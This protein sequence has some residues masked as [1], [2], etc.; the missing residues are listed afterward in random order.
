MAGTSLDGVD[1]ALVAFAP[2]GTP[3]LERF[4]TTPYPDRLRNDLLALIALGDVPAPLVLDDALGRLF[5]E[6][7]IAVR[8]DASVDFVG[9]H[10]QTVW[11]D[12]GVASRQIGNPAIIAAACH[13]PVVSDFRRADIAA[14]GQGAP[15]VPL[16]DAV[17]F[18][19]PDG[20]RTLLNIGGMANATYVPRLGVEDG[21]IAFDTGPGV[22][23]MD[24]VA[25][26]VDPAL[27]C[28]LDGRLA[29]AGRA[30]EALLAELLADPWFEVP[31][32]KS[33][34]RER[35]GQAVAERIVAAC[36]RTSDA[37]ATATAFTARSIVA[38]LDRW[39]PSSRGDLLVAGGGLH[40]RTL[41]TSLPPFL[42]F[43]DCFFNADAKEALV[44]AWLGW[45]TLHGLPGN[46]PAATGARG[47]RVLGS[48]VGTGI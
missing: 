33:T 29:A 30:D 47:P 6:A 15:L 34:G 35:F 32:P 2:D 23:I 5:A 48:V 7:A 19:N 41:C 17:L 1:A 11:H 12:P 4:V 39:L 9:S 22:A 36:G 24:L 26:A 37:V 3:T 20:P 16:A 13:V 25:R 28:D 14:G 38:Q 10:G 8:A 18:G 45:R 46:L 31:P 43:S 42:P 44:F 27:R 21:V 40:N